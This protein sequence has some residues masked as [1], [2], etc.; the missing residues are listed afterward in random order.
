MMKKV[1]M[2]LVLMLITVCAFSQTSTWQWGTQAGGSD[3]DFSDGIEIDENGN[4]YVTGVFRDTATFGS[5]SLISSGVSDIFAAKMDANGN[6]LWATKAGGSDSDHGKGIA[7]DDT[8]NSFVTGYFNGTATFGSY[9]LTSYGSYDIFVAKMDAN[10]N[11]LW[12]T[13]AGGSHYDEGNGI[14]IDDDGNSYVTGY[15]YGTATF[16][17]YSLSSY[18]SYDIF[19]AKIDANGNWLWATKAGG[20]DSDQGKG[21]AIDDTGN[22]Y[23]T[24]SFRDTA[25]FGSYSL[26]SSGVS[27]IFA[28]KMDANGNWLWAT[29]AGGSDSDFSRGIAIDDNGNNYVTGD[30]RDT[31]TFGSYSLT[32]GGG[33]Y[34]SDIFVA[35][36][37]ATGNWLWASK[38]GGGYLDY[39]SAIAL[40]DNGNSYVTGGFQGTATFG[41]YSFTSSGILD[42][43]VAKID[44]NGNWLWAYKAGG[45]NSDEGNGIAID[46]NGNNYVTGSFMDTATFGYFSLTSSGDHDIFVA[47]LNNNISYDITF[48]S[49][50]DLNTARY[51]FAHASD[52]DYLYAICGGTYEP[53]L[54]R[55]NNIEKYNPITD[56]WT[57]FTDGLISRVFCRVEY[58][59][60]TNKLY[61]F[62]GYIGTALSFTD[63]VEVVDG[64]TGSVTYLIS[65]PI[66]NANSGT[67]VWNNK[68]YIFGGTSINGYSSELYEFDPISNEWIQLSDMP[69]AKETEGE[70]VDGILYVFGGY[71]GS[72]SNRIDAYNIQNSEWTF[73]DYMPV[74][75]SAH[76]TVV[77]GQYIWLIGGY[78]NLESV[79]VFNTETH[80]FTQ[81]NTNMIGRRHCGTEVIGNNLY[82]FGGNIA[83]GGPALSSLQ[84]VDI[85]Y[86]SIDDEPN[87]IPSSISL[88]Q[89]YPNPFNPATK[90]HYSIKEKSIV[91]IVVYNLKGQLV[92]TLINGQQNAGDHSVIWNGNDE[93]NK[94]VSSGVY[95]YKLNI[96]DRTEEVKKCLLMK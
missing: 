47:K 20:S 84:Y 50:S 16:D 68:I 10:G 82:V 41:S 94:P 23:V 38:A 86:L 46:D 5:Y 64:N 83:S 88:F 71:N 6:W 62:G 9:S 24:G 27:D 3:L 32:T 22:S 60:T 56:N 11:W 92:K 57:E 19:V 66:L 95:F 77:S 26:I 72:V 14:S 25:T 1:I 87:V 37:D 29:K 12:A 35:K 48:N 45:S 80:E 58:I 28:A 93:F 81:L 8:G 78:D 4:S 21:I 76:H 63:T 59:Q 61:I 43:F 67:A 39:S 89:N 31:A 69:E 74:A 36:M 30:F 33:N 18:G 54:Y 34:D 7:I 79:A 73:I 55:V 53:P 85:S 44:A 90:I 40:D 51:G 17:S 2:N 91:K 15:Y 49:L 13:K 52:G 75:I 70:V 96:N 42:I 65:D